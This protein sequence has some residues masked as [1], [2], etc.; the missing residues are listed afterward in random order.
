MCTYNRGY[1]NHADPETDSDGDGGSGPKLRGRGHIEFSKKGIPHGI[2]HFPL[3]LQLAGH[4]YMHDTCAPEASHRFNI[5]TAMDRVRKLTESETSNSLIEWGFRVRTW[6][7]VIDSVEIS[8][9][10]VGRKLNAPSSMTVLLSDLYL[11]GTFSPLRVGGDKLLCND[12]RI[13]FCELATMISNH[14]GWDVDTVMDDVEVRLYCSARVLHTSGETRTYWATESRYQYRD[15][16]RRD[17]VEIDLGEGKI[18]VGEITSFIEMSAGTVDMTNKAV[19]IRWM[20]KSSLS[21]L[22]D[23]K[24]RPLCDFPMSCNHCLWEW[25]DAGRR[26]VSFRARG[27]RNRCVS[28]NLWSHVHEDDRRSVIDSEIRARYD[29]IAYDSIK[30]HANI[31][32]DPSTGH[33]LQTLQIL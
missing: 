5:K 12:V 19:I 14:M 11:V 32:E 1:N 8:D 27:F 16:R 13:S 23:D 31:H 26:R 7:K 18:G 20:S 28:Q 21:T 6:A 3:Q 30:R 10:P 22:R 2:L 25:S 24:D 15:G 33:M 4:I 29:I 17:K 9:T